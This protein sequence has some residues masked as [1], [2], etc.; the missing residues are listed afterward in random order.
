MPDMVLSYGAVCILLLYCKS[1]YTKEEAKLGSILCSEV[2]FLKVV[3]LA[4]L[5]Y[6]FVY[7]VCSLCWE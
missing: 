6:L 1:T 4:K 5:L 2:R 3:V 7:R